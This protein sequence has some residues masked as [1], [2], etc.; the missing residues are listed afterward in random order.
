[1]IERN[2][3]MVDHASALLAVYTGA[4]R[5]GTGATVNYARKLGQKIIM[6]NPITQNIICEGNTP[7]THS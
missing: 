7:P 3:F 5:S 1:M 4:Q 6:I 2:H